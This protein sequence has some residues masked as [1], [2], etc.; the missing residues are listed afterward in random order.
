MLAR[1]RDIVFLRYVLAS[2]LALGID[3]G[4][5]FALLAAGTAPAL[6]AAAGY[7]VGIVAHWLVSSRKVFQAGVAE[8]GPGRTRQKAMF[9]FSALLG[10][11]VTAGIVALGSAAGADPR[12]AK[13]VAIGVSFSITWL[14]R[15]RI[16][17]R[18]D[19]AA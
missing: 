1:L 17:F 7:A 2:A 6:A 10:L 12:L 16:I 3:L 18:P 14:L 19:A 13:L 4:T 11:A 8:R 15:E 9:V 5:F